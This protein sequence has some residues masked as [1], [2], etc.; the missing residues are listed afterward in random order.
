MGLLIDICLICINW[1]YKFR[2]LFDWLFTW[3]FINQSMRTIYLFIRIS[4]IGVIKRLAKFG[5]FGKNANILLKYCVLSGW[6]QFLDFSQ[7]S[8]L[9]L[10]QFSDWI[11]AGMNQFFG[12]CPGKYKVLLWRMLI[13]KFVV[14]E[15]DERI[16]SGI[17][18]DD[19]L[20]DSPIH[21]YKLT[22]Q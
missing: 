1:S 4:S 9:G 5:V 7:Q 20:I 8:I 21:S 2:A 17:G 11:E 13:Q 12:I 15:N 14:S 10:I 6:I 19:W 3:W 22:T 18:I 16:L